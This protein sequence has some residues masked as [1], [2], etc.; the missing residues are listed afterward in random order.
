M[1]RIFLFGVSS[2]FCINKV[3]AQQMDG[4]R[5]GMFLNDDGRSSGESL[6]GGFMFLVLTGVTWFIK[7]QYLKSGKDNASAWLSAIGT[8]IVLFIVIAIVISQS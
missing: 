3:I 7:E 8:V 2:I 4:G 6:L 5:E 1:K